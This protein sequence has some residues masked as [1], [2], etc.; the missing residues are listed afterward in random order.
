M[1]WHPPSWVPKL[2]GTVLSHQ[3]MLCSNFLSFFL[4]PKLMPS[5]RAPRLHNRRG[6]PLQRALRS[7]PARAVQESL[8]MRHHGQDLYAR[9]GHQA[10]RPHGQG[11]WKTSALHSQRGHRVG[12]RCDSLLPQHSRSL[13]LFTLKKPVL[14]LCGTVGKIK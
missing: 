6:V 5:I 13:P 4:N 9:R 3:P 1:V 2:P 10:H 12:S 14:L 11:H 7:T 8:H